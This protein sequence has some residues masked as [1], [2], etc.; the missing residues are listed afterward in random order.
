FGVLPMNKSLGALIAAAFIAPAALA[1]T[2][3]DSGSWIVRVRA[4]NLDSANKDSTGL[5]LSINNKVIPDVDISY[6]FSPNLATDLVLTYPQRHDLR[7]GGAKIGSFKHLPPTLTLQ[8]HV[9]GLA[10]WRPY[11]GAG[12]NYTRLSN[13][14]FDPAVVAA[15]D[16][17]VKKNSWGLA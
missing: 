9:T 10:G 2:A 7:P 1:Q 11:V 3:P 17:S 8:Y 13:V 14:E 12:I 15:L 16:P 5:D 4:L 6:F